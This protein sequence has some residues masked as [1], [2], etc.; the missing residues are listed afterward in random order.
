MN[1]QKYNFTCFDFKFI[2]KI[3]AI[4]ALTFCSLKAE[5]EDISE[6]SVF[7]NLYSI[8]FINADTGFCV[9]TSG[10]SAILMK[11]IDGGRQWNVQ[12]FQ[13]KIF[14]DLCIKN[15]DTFFISGYS[16]D[17]RCG[18][19][20]RCFNFGE[21]FDEIFFNDTINPFSFGINK[22]ILLNDNRMFLCGF[23]GAIFYS[24]DLGK[25]W[26]KT[27][28]DSYTKNFIDI[29][30]LNDSVGYAVGGDYNLYKINNIYKTIDSGKSW[31][32]IFPDDSSILQISSIYFLS[33]DNGFIFGAKDT[34]EAILK[35][36]DTCKSWEIKYLGNNKILINKGYMLDSLIGFATG[37]IGGIFKTVDGGNSWQIE[38]RISSETMNDICAPIYNDTIKVLYACGDK[39]TI[40]KYKDI[41]NVKDA[42][43]SNHF[44]SFY[45]IKLPYNIVCNNF[46]FKIYNLLGEIIIERKE[47]NFYNLQEI[48]DSLEKG[49]YLIVFLDNDGLIQNF[50]LL[51]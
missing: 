21:E 33:E 35:T 14:L 41:V 18:L 16:F 44:I 34:I 12:T 38:P 1:I 43:N 10:S 26:T 50:K 20:V 48:I 42:T 27:N 47:I 17:R 11:T 8:K 25:T 9:G 28:T 30:M 37:E 13:G 36:K 22:T 7:E 31:T 2:F 39:G 46:D 32:P 51:K 24:E 29:Q 19:L 49:F 3:I 6:K 4:L 40:L 15:I 5:W 45:G 23:S